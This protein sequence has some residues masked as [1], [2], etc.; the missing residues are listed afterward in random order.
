MKCGS[1]TIWDIADIL[2][3]GAAYQGPVRKI[4][5]CEDAENADDCSLDQGSMRCATARL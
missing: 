5:T 4:I 3:R 2:L 1:H